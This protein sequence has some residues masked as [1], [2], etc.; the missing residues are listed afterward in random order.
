MFLQVGRQLPPTPLLSKI[1]YNDFDY[2]LSRI[3]FTLA[4][5]L[6]HLI[7]EHED[8]GELSECEANF[9]AGYLLA[10]DPIVIEYS[11]LE[12][13]DIEAKF[14]VSHECAKVVQR[15][16]CNR[17]RCGRRPMSHE[18]QLLAQCNLTPKEVMSIG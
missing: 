9:A 4:H 6:A 18:I 8:D 14:G 16:A 10:P 17:R 12:T 13:H 15:H 1:F 11:S 3:R 7:L 2:S 5:E